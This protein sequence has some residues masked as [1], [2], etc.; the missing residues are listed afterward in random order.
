MA[1]NESKIFLNLN[2]LKAIT[3]RHDRVQQD[4]ILAKMTKADNK[5]FSNRQS[6]RARIKSNPKV[7]REKERK[8]LRKK[9]SVTPAKEKQT[10]T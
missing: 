3:K 5:G 10:R 4:D 6:K 8:A 9:K 2:V 1:K 7:N